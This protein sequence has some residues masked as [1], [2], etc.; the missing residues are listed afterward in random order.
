LRLKESIKHIL[1]VGPCARELGRTVRRLRY[2]FIQFRSAT[3]WEARYASGG[4]S[5]PGSEGHLAK[6]KA[7]VLNDFV[8][9]HA[10][11]SVIEL[12]CGDGNQLSLSEYPQY[13][14]IDVSPTAI[15][16]CQELFQHDKSKRFLVSRENCAQ[17][18]E[19]AELA[20][21]LDVIFHLVED[22]V[23]EQYMR[24]LFDAATRFVIIYSDNQEASDQE[25]HVRH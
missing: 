12:G 3:Y 21:S 17:N 9:R 16:R 25:L 14:G 22:N 13:V 15:I 20:L 10:I 18:P 4:V 6:F 23:Y 1:M 2:R 11:K 8:G 19:P 7:K 24:S 5:G